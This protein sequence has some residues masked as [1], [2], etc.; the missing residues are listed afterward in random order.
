MSTTTWDLAFF[1]VA[2]LTAGGC[3]YYYVRAVM[4]G[5]RP[6]SRAAAAGCFVFGVVAA[7]MLVRV[8]L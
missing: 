6:L 8:L 1:A 5:D 4:D 3:A 7:I 2:L